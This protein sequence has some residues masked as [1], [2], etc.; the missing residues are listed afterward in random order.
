MPQTAQDYRI[1]VGNNNV[2]GLV[3][4]EAITVSSVE[5]NPVRSL[6]YTPGEFRTRTNGTSFL[7]GFPSTRWQIGGMTAAQYEHLKTTYCGGGY[8]GL[9]TIKTTLDTT[10]YSNLNAVLTLPTTD[11]LERVTVNT[12]DNWYYLDVVLLFTR[13]EA[14]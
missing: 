1:A 5:M 3:V 8:S 6:G 11:S 10:A 14:V 4:W 2:A 12:I 9:V 7:A 13:L